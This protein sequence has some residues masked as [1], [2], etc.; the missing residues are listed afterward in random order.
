MTDYIHYFE[1]GS[2]GTTLTT[3]NTGTAP[4]T[5]FNTVTGGAIW[6]FSSTGKIR[7]SL[8]CRV[9]VGATSTAWRAYDSWTA[10]GQIAGRVGFVWNGSVRASTS[11]CGVVNTSFATVVK[12]QTDASGKLLI[13]DAAGATLA[14]TAAALSPG[15]AYYVELQVA[16][17]TTT[18][19]GTVKAQLYAV[20]TPG[21]LLINLNNTA[22]NAGTAQLV[23]GQL[24]NNDSVTSMDLTFDDVQWSTGTLVALGPPPAANLPPNAVVDS[25]VTADAWVPVAHSGSG[26]NDP[27]GTIVSYA[28]TQ[29]GGT[30][31]TLTGAATA[32]VSYTAPATRT[33]TT[34]TLRL[35]VTDN[36]G[37]TATATVT[38]T[39]NAVNEFAVQGG[40]EVP[41]RIY[42]VG[43]F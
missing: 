12:V 19:N 31:V 43:T 36:Q 27:D 40:Q 24:G 17:G 25:A 4:D 8:G 35:T 11:V 39:I 16:P 2:D 1:G 5:A 10:V 26:S 15:T 14:T 13:Q 22:C 3:T 30:A 38:D 7:G 21:T 20:A 6:T 41:I 34:V 42:A 29:T 18:T 23:R 32:N 9:Q 37:V 28:W 33:G